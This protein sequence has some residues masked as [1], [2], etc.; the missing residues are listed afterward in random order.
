[1]SIEFDKHK[2]NREESIGTNAI[3]D[4][5]RVSELSNGNKTSAS[6]KRVSGNRDK[7]ENSRNPMLTKIAVASVILVVGF[8]GGVIFERAIASSGVVD[9][10]QAVAKVEEVSDVAS[11][12]DELNL[13]VEDTTG[14]Q[15][16]SKTESAM[17]VSNES[18]EPPVVVEDKT[19]TA[20]ESKNT[21]YE[22]LSA[23]EK[24]D[25]KYLKSADTWSSSKVKSQ[26]FKNMFAQ[27]NSGNIDCL[28]TTFG[29]YDR[30]YVNGYVVNLISSIKKLSPEG[31][32]K[33]KKYLTEGKVGEI[34][35]SWAA[36]QIGKMTK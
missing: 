34:K 24:E 26:R 35:M 28:E 33:A 6:K 29:G 18:E 10:S 22:S 12:E 14:V 36:S 32:E 2:I 17:P 7:N 9:D 3:E 11:E 19:S 23:E 4:G 16:D 30:E 1:M 15:D 25:I 31:R 21:P 5:G 20:S 27:L 13:P 8:A